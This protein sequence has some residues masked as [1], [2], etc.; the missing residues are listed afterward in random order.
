MFL[1]K[2]YP[3][4]LR[5][6]LA[7]ELRE[8]L[9]PEAPEVLHLWGEPNAS[10]RGAM[11]TA[12][13]ARGD[14]ERIAVGSASTFDWEQAYQRLL[15]ACLDAWGPAGPTSADSSSTPGDPG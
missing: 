1:H 3:R 4:S 14:V 15:T 13:V 6:R 8:K 10:L 9:G 11:L 5:K 2:A 12:H 7:V